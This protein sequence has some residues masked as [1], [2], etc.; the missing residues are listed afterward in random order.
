MLTTA[1]EI[2]TEALMLIKVIAASEE[3]DAADMATGLRN[4][5]TLTDSWSI[6]RNFIYAEAVETFDLVAAQAVYTIGP[7]A[8]AG[9]FATAVP[10]EVLESTFVRVSQLDYPL[11]SLTEEQYS[12]IGLKT[13]QGIPQVFLFTK[14]PTL[15]TLALYP[16]PLADQEIELHSLKPLTVFP[17]LDTATT[18]MPGYTEA[19]Q[20]TLAERLAPKFETDASKF[21]IAEA[22][23]LRKALARSNVVVPT[24][25]LDSVPATVTSGDPW[26]GGWAVGGADG[27]VL[28]P[29]P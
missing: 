21:V 29:V 16:V 10:F 24:L 4:L 7:L 18:L 28:V 19:L 26:G 6:K 12:S 20:F 22:M 9:N 23:K 1:R 2:I 17:A 25:R 13:S 27:D 15:A 8:T 14:H 11:R 5:N 3:G